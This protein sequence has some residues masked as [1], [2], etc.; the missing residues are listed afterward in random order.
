MTCLLIFAKPRRLRRNFQPRGAQ[1]VPGPGEVAGWGLAL[2]IGNWQLAIGNEATHP[3]P[4][5][6]TYAPPAMSFPDCATLP[7]LSSS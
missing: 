1:G 6:G 4:R 5:G 2:L 3:L 7:A